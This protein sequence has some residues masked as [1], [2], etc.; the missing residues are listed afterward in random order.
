MSSN[1]IQVFRGHL[2]IFGRAILFIY[3]LN[4]FGPCRYFDYLFCI[5]S[6]IFEKNVLCRK[7]TR[8]VLGSCIQAGSN[9]SC[10]LLEVLYQYFRDPIIDVFFFSQ[11]YGGLKTLLCW[12][13]AKGKI[14]DLAFVSYASFVMG[15]FRS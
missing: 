12:T 5:S 3:P 6:N 9:F 15:F 2:F 8:N 10:S 14:N 13:K 11:K 4:I 7:K 1:F